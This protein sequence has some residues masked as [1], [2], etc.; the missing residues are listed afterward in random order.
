[1]LL[2]AFIESEVASNRSSCT[3]NRC[4]STGI[5]GRH[6]HFRHF[7]ILKEPPVSHQPPQ[8][9]QPADK[10]AG[11]ISLG[12]A[13]SSIRSGSRVALPHKAAASKPSQRTGRPTAAFWVRNLHDSVQ[14]RADML[15][16]AI[17]EDP[18]SQASMNRRDL[19]A[20][21][22]F[23]LPLNAI[24]AVVEYTPGEP[25][26]PPR[27]LA[28]FADLQGVD[29]AR[30][31]PDAVP[32]SGQAQSFAVSKGELSGHE[33]TLQKLDLSGHLQPGETQRPAPGEDMRFLP[34]SAFETGQWIIEEIRQA[35][36]AR[37]RNLQVSP[38]IR[39]MFEKRQGSS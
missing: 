14:R 31:S 9:D 18:G 25:I 35:P 27:P 4:H 1:M 2:I 26:P 3:S 12:E 34:S 5:W 29:L 20:T 13:L 17:R 32:R 19:M 23:T 21:E 38:L 37:G 39:Q 33:E 24:T 22:R 36:R 11:T 30:V 6:L 28:T 10:G 16:E 15:Y 7:F 8:G